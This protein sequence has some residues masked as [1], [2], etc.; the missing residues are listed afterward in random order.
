MVPFSLCETGFNLQYYEKIFII[1]SHHT[2]L[3]DLRPG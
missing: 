3:T 1:N 2:L